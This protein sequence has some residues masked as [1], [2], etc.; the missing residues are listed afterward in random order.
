LENDLCH[1]EIPTAKIVGSYD[2]NLSLSLL[3]T[4]VSAERCQTPVTGQNSSVAADQA[5]EAIQSVR[6]HGAQG[7]LPERSTK[8]P[9]EMDAFVIPSNP[10]AEE[11][12][13]TPIRK[14]PKHGELKD[15]NDWKKRANGLSVFVSLA[16]TDP[17]NRSLVFAF[18][19][20]ERYVSETHIG[21]DQ[22]MTGI[23]RSAQN[24]IHILDRQAFLVHALVLPAETTIHLQR[25]QSAIKLV[26]GDAIGSQDN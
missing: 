9:L 19:M 5:L 21:L 22:V 8:A 16:T 11:R 25:I 14:C 7:I 18:C 13:W 26:C 3:L 12:M 20:R 24:H 15:R 6:R 10:T 23:M 4:V 1:N 2:G 17:I